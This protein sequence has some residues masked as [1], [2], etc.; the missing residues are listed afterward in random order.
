MSIKHGNNTQDHFHSL[1]VVRRDAVRRQ[2]L[3]TMWCMSCVLLSIHLKFPRLS[4]GKTPPL[5]HPLGFRSL[6]FRRHHRP[7]R[8]R[9]ASARRLE[10]G[11]LRR[12]FGH[13]RRLPPLAPTM[14]LRP[15][16]LRSPSRRAYR[17]H[18]RPDSDCAPSVHVE[19][20]AHGVHQR[21]GHSQRAAF[22]P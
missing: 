17:P 6:C 14:H 15:Y 18:G 2:D 9:Q 22:V 19:R 16:G 3:R 5:H 11:P 21:P 8:T 13:Q 10:P 1:A 20:R 7:E 4:A 12:G